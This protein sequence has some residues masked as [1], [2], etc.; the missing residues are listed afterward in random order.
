[1]PFIRPVRPLGLMSTVA[2]LC[3]VPIACLA[4]TCTVS[5]LEMN[6]GLYDPRVPSPTLTTGTVSFSCTA[7]VPVEI[8]FHGVNNA[9]R[10]GA[11]LTS[12]N[13]QL[14]FQLFL[15][16]ARTEPLGD[17]LN[18]TQYY[19]NPAPPANIVVT[20]PIFGDIPPGQG[21]AGAG[22]YVDML[23]LEIDTQ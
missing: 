16:P 21:N 11:Y 8:K 14:N 19:S 23:T 17:G 13:H 5:S 6:F 4:Q 12:R 7:S 15:D 20:V 3:A 9:G 1:M 10:D 22:D 2:A 18:G